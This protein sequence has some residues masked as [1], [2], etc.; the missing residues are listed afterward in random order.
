M[1]VIHI[2]AAVRDSPHGLV[3]G[4]RVVVV[5]YL[6][7]KECLN[8][9]SALVRLVERDIVE[10]VVGDMG[11]SD[12]VVKKAECQW[13]RVLPIVGALVVLDMAECQAK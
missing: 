4:G 2:M 12:L 5:K 7:L 6:W 11:G 1:K 10:Q 13:R 3:P 8:G 9:D